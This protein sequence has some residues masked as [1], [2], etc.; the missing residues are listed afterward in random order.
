MGS[1]Y[2]LF[3]GADAHQQHFADVHCFDEAAGT[4]EK[5]NL[6]I[7]GHTPGTQRKYMNN[8]YVVLVQKNL[9]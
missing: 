3:G 4:W 1:K 5:V 6:S 8:I 9:E 2:L 7:I